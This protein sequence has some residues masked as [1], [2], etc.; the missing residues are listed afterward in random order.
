[1]DVDIDRCFLLAYEIGPSS[2]IKIWFIVDFL[3][4][5]SKT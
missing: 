4:L 2:N 1:M 5:L 3:S